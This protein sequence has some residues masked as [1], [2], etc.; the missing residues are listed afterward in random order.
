MSEG[1]AGKATI[2]QELKERMPELDLKLSVLGHVQ[3]GGA[4]SAS[5][6]LLATKLSISS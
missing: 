2:M 5:D 4:P 6:R 3:R 1:Y